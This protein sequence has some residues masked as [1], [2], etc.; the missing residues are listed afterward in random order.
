MFVCPTCHF[1]IRK[2]RIGKKNQG[3]NQQTVYYF[4]IEKWKVCPL[5]DGCYKNGAKSKTYA[6]PKRFP[7]LDI[8]F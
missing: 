4:D 1:A 8:L 7:F 6:L 2:V 3:A 5:S